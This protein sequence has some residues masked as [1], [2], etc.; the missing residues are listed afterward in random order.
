MAPEAATTTPILRL[1]RYH[2]FDGGPLA[3]VSEENKGEIAAGIRAIVTA[4][5]PVVA[6][7]AYRLYVLASGGQRVGGGIRSQ[8][9][10][11]VHQE[12]RSGRLAA[13]PDGTPGVVDRTLMLPGTTPVVLRELGPRELTEVPRSEVREVI[14][15]LGLGGQTGEHVSR[16]VLQAYGLTRLTGRAATFLAECQKYRWRPAPSDGEN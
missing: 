12:L 16:A 2:R 14:E 4:E 9:N 11:I 8:L 6:F 10:K 15:Q 5:G 3:P 7:R 13:I 1:A